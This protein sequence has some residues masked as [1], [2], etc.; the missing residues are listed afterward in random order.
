[1]TI[2]LEDNSFS[3]QLG[4]ELRKGMERKEEKPPNRCSWSA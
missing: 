4:K 2:M 1:M 3:S